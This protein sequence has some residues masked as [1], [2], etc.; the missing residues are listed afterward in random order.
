MF[1]SDWEKKQHDVLKSECCWNYYYYFFSNMPLKSCC[2]EVVSK[3][4][5]PTSTPGENKKFKDALKT[6]SCPVST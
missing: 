5:N 3:C 6:K 2:F 4:S 1:L